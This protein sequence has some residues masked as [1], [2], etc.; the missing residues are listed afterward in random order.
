MHSGEDWSEETCVAAE[1]AIGYT[2]K[3]RILLKTC[4]THKSYTNFCGEEN[5]ERLE[6]LGDAVLGLAVTEMLYHG[7][8]ADEGRLTERRK[9]FVS[10]PALEAAES[11]AGLMRFLRFSGGEENVNG[12]TASN[13]FE[14]V[15]AG[16]YLDGGTEEV[17]RFLKRYLSQ[18]ETENY[19]T[20]LQE[21][22]QERTKSTPFYSV[23]EE[24]GGY[25]CRVAALGLEATGTGESKKAAETGAAKNLY[26]KLTERVC[27]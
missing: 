16:I 2:F 17:K 1:E 23:R 7:D 20:M 27:K 24:N 21:Y 10:K 22:V 9:Q 14:A 25:S 19:K 26:T 8:K 6:F 4:F 5:N 13:L 11:K 12:K 3:D 15:T 18:I